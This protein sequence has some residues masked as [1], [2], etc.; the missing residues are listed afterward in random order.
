MSRWP[1]SISSTLTNTNSLDVQ[2]ITGGLTVVVGVG[3]SVSTSETTTS[4]TLA[5][6][7]S[8]AQINDSVTAYIN[9]ST[10]TGVG[11]SLLNSNDAIVLAD[12]STEIGIG[13]GSL[14]FSGQYGLGVALTYV[15]ID[16]PGGCVSNPGSCYATNAF[17][18]NSSVS[19]FANIDVI[20]EAPQKVYA[21]A[22]TIQ[23][24]ASGAEASLGGAL[25]F[26]TLTATTAASISNT[27]STALTISA[28]QSVNVVA[29]SSSSDLVAVQPTTTTDSSSSTYAADFFNVSTTN[30][31]AQSAQSA[32][33]SGSSASIVSVAG[34]IQAGGASA[35][36]VSLVVNN[37]SETDTASLSGVNVI[38]P[39][40]VSVSATDTTTIFSL[41]VGIGVATVG[42]YAFEGSSV[43]NTIGGGANATVGAST[44]PFT[45]IGTSSSNK[46]VGSLTVGATDLSNVTAI[47]L[48]GSYAETGAAGIAISINN[49]ETNTAAA[50]QSAS[51]Y[52]TVNQGLPAATGDI[53]VESQSTG[54]ILAVAAG[55]S[56]S[57]TFAGE[58]SVTTNLANGN[59][60]ST[61]S[62][63]TLFAQNNVGVL[64]ANNNAINAVA[65]SAG[66]GL[67]TE[68][69]GISVTVNTIGGTSTTGE[70]YA[71]IIASTVDAEASGAD[72]L[73]IID[74]ALVVGATQTSSNPQSPSAVTP[75]ST[76]NLGQDVRNDHGLAVVAGSYESSIVVAVTLGAGQGLADADNAVTNTLGGYTKAM[77][78][79][80]ILDGNLPLSSS[81]PVVDVAARSVSFTNNLDIAVA[82]TSGTGSD[83][84]ALVINSMDRTTIASIAATSVGIGGTVSGVAEASVGAVKVSAY[85]WE[86]SSTEAVGGSASTG[87]AGTGS[88]VANT[89]Q[90]NTTA[91]VDQGTINAVS[92]AVTANNTAGFFG[93]AGNLTGG[94]T[95]GLGATVIVLISN[96][97]T[98]ATV[99]DTDPQN[100]TTSQSYRW[101]REPCLEHCRRYD[102]RRVELCDRRSVRRHRRSRRAVFRHVHLQQY[103]GGARQ[104]DGDGQQVGRG[105]RRVHGN[106]L[107]RPGGRRP[108]GRRHRRH[109]RCRQPSHA[110]EQRRGV[111]ERRHRHHRRR[112]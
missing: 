8:V 79:G 28:I 72:T 27:C 71:K 68:G 75:Y 47:A 23:G 81:G 102:G 53:I 82:L 106:R 48:V 93:V 9:N 1:T 90:A 33:N 50:I 80:S 95:A 87:G 20:A 77:V 100:A 84:N 46:L 39:S 92:L 69:L 44:G 7:V 78:S 3:V 67:S 40:S 60:T 31:S 98:T 49:I 21:A 32:L 13:G 109:R 76:P 63:S 108:S 103:P 4:G 101:R 104:Y 35:F 30:S 91:S 43:A 45:T 83:A 14:S 58:G 18:L 99:G 97:T 11:T 12:Q 38:A 56:A 105:G 107:Y 62:G 55:I 16:N 42:P 65:G 24:S 41:A 74:G 34:V 26:D 70:T 89:F 51:V 73:Q 2:A 36:G 57:Q 52:T 10:I 59:V 19:G 85:G 110:H 61:V 112:R 88:A 86:S 111:D 37:V 54:E 94:E 22:A 29:G 5:G 25:I 15:K 64:A 66:I 17:I 96:V 6:S